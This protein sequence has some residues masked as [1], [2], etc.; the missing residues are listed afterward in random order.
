MKKFLAMMLAMVMVLG[1]SVT[2]LAEEHKPV[3]GDSAAIT[4]NGVKTG[5]TVK[6][7]KIAEGNWNDFGFTGYSAI[8]VGDYKI[9]DLSKPT[10]QEITDIAKAVDANEGTALSEKPEGSGVYTA[11]LEV[12]MYLILV[13]KNGTDDM[14]AYNPMIASVY[15][16]TDKTGDI[17]DQIGGS[18]DATTDFVIDG[19]TLF[20]KSMNPG[21]T[22]EIV[23]P[24]EKDNNKYG[25]DTAIGDVITFE[26]KTAFPGYSDEYTE[27]EF[28]I[29][30]TLSK[31]LTLVADSVNVIEVAGAATPPVKGTD[32]TVTSSTDSDTGITT[33]TIS[34]TSDY[35]LAHRGKDVTVRYNASLNENAGLNFD[36]NTNTVKAE[37]TNNPTTNDKGTT[38]E[39][40]TY[41][42]TFGIDASINGLGSTVTEELLK[43][44]EVIKNPDT[45][46]ETVEPL[47]GATFTLTNKTTNKVYTTISGIGE[48]G[49]EVDENG[50]PIN[51]DSYIK[52]SAG[53]LKFT[54]LDA[55]EYELQETKAPDGYT[56]NPVKIPVEITAEY[57]TDGT[58][59]SYV[60]KV[61][62]TVIEKDTEKTSTYTATYKK[63]DTTGEMDQTP[64]N[65][66]S[67]TQKVPNTKIIGLPSTGGIGTTIFTI[68]GCAIMIIAAGLFFA[69][70]RKKVK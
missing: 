49:K 5:A 35:I 4:V 69:S 9:E 40:R 20:A 31:G 64:G 30:D 32:Y 27:V 42:Y 52:P 19:Q 68:G 34:F 60:I 8:E 26:V 22:K 63:N 11:E 46:E 15:Y 25:N 50:T 55:G 48:V 57:N 14:T 54:G 43:T 28:N 65:V 21:I 53:Y 37:Y 16:S 44:G 24:L 2:A 58:L 3:P 61:D 51:A 6:A 23:S 47:D 10:A 70:R 62:G 12:G 1:M 18:V 41:H 67:D 33:M 56:L 66:N 38:E 36:K 13:T 39:K 45:G 29:V 59:N 17:N 7:Y